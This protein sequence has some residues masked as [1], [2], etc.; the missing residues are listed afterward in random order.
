M[1]P[2]PTSEPAARAATG[3]GVKLVQLAGMIALC[4]GVA[5][6]IASDTWWLLWAI[7]AFLGLVVWLAGRFA[8]W[9]KYG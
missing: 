9:W 1:T 5:G 3:R 2:T 4:A 7:V 6:V 8:A